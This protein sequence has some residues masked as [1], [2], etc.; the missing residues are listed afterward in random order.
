MPNQL[1][2]DTSVVA[3]ARKVFAAGFICW[4]AV[5]SIFYSCSEAGMSGIAGKGDTSDKEEGPAS[6]T[7]TATETGSDEA[8]WINGSYLTCSW[9]EISEAN[10]VTAA[11]RMLSSS[12]TRRPD[13]LDMACSTQDAETGVAVGQTI[14]K[15]GLAFHV[16]LRAQQI[17][18]ARL[19]CQVSGQDAASSKIETLVSV[20]AGAASAELL[21]CLN[22]DAAGSARACV[23]KAGISIGTEPA[24][25]DGAGTDSGIEQDDTP[26]A[27]PK[28]VATASST[29]SSTAE[30]TDAG[31]SA[32]CQPREQVFMTP[33]EH[34]IKLDNPGCL[35]TVHLWGAG[36]GG[37]GGSEEGGTAGGTGGSTMFGSE[38]VAGGTGGSSTTGGMGGAGTVSPSTRIVVGRNGTN[39]PAIIIGGNGGSAPDATSGSLPAAGSAG[40]KGGSGATLESGCAPGESGGG[41]GGGGLGGGGGGSGGYASMEYPPGTLSVPKMTLTIGA[42]GTSG[43]PAGAKGGDGK[44]LL[45]WE[46]YD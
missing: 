39:A 1:K 42:G 15:T 24:D 45:I 5:A 35:L 33:G 25:D 21:A 11:C 43:C 9:L 19:D 28:S 14:L 36:G 17:A 29:A 34:E 18:K 31:S 4:C 2:I 7:S 26:A 12:G 16:K 6:S 32:D 38:I 13:G 10:D 40:G 37:S 20:L 27:V 44:A 8:V 22:N 30:A 23:A 46:V 41:G 3:G